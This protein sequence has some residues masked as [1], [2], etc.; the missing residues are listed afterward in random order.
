M[1][2]TF[3]NNY[4]AI[5]ETK[6]CGINERQG[7]VEYY[8]F[9]FTF[10]GGVVR[11]HN[12][13][14]RLDIDPGDSR[15]E[16]LLAKKIAM[17]PTRYANERLSQLKD[18]VSGRKQ[19][20]WVPPTFWA[21]TTHAVEPDFAEVDRRTDELLGNFRVVDAMRAKCSGSVVVESQGASTTV[22]TVLPTEVDDVPE[23]IKMALPAADIIVKETVEY[24]E[25][26]FQF[27]PVVGNATRNWARK[28]IGKGSKCEI[29]GQQAHDIDLISHVPDEAYIWLDAKKTPRY[30]SMPQKHATRHTRLEIRSPH[31]AG[32]L[33]TAG[34]QVFD[35]PEA[36][37]MRRAA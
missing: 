26:L 15:F 8:E 18:V 21:I 31:R 16:E 34:I 9:M 22:L 33:R 25:P 10:D 1:I 14:Y 20:L 17:D 7:V 3:S 6:L 19:G 28:Q 32:A 27:S 23:G 5:N 24:G 12:T 11:T 37:N 13:Q 4:A 30:F 35:A 29:N 36:S 2:A